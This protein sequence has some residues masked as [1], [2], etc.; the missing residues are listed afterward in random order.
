MMFLALATHVF[1]VRVINCALVVRAIGA[2]L[3]TKKKMAL[4][5][6]KDCP[7]QDTQKWLSKCYF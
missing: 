6:L 2:M 7:A 4:F 3:Q 5:G 1:E